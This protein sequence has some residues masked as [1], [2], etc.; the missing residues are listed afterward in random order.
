MDESPTMMTPPMTRAPDERAVIPLPASGA[1]EI[2]IWLAEARGCDPLP[3]TPPQDT[4]SSDAHPWLTTQSGVGLGLNDD[5]LFENSWSMPPPP[6]TDYS[7]AY[8]LSGS[9]TALLYERARGSAS[10]AIIPPMHT[11][12]SGASGNRRY[13]DR[14]SGTQ[15]PSPYSQQI[16]EFIG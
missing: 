5:Y 14:A 6:Q 9:P 3:E 2:P 7:M 8:G 11:G 10:A 15:L 13:S 4:G 1:P 16:N 12:G